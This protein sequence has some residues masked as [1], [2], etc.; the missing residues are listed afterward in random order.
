M[1]RMSFAEFR[2]SSQAMK[3]VFGATHFKQQLGDG[4]VKRL[5]LQIVSDSW[6]QVEFLGGLHTIGPVE[7]GLGNPPC[8]MEV[9]HQGGALNPSQTCY[10]EMY[11]KSF[12][13]LLIM[14]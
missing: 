10:P 7:T 13:A 9:L 4:R 2:R 11:P 1:T 12:N 5:E 6:G 8:I 14:L 3:K